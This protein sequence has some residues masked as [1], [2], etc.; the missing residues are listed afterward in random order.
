MIEEFL[1]T[2]PNNT[3]LIGVS[4]I[5]SVLLLISFIKK[6][7]KL[8]LITLIGLII[9]AG[10]LYFT[11]SEPSEKAKQILENPTKLINEKSN[12]K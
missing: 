9:Y 4:I 2:V 5:V 11:N 6:I 12:I 1:S 7:E 3:E 10:Y 8:A